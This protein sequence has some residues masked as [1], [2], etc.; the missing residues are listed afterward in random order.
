MRIGVNCY[1]MQPH[2]GG[3]RQYLINLLNQVVVYDTDNT[4]VLFCFE[5]NIRYLA[6]I[7]SDRWLVD[8]VHLTAMAQ[9]RHHLRDVDVYFS[10][11]N[12]LQPTALRPLPTVIM[13]PDAQEVYYPRYFTAADLFYRDWYCR[14]SSHLAD[15]VITISHFSKQTIA[16]HYRLSPDR[17][18][19]AYPCIDDRF[20]RA[21]TIARAPD[22]ALPETFILYPANRWRHKNHAALLQ[23]MQLIQR[24]SGLRIH[25]VF[26]GVDE[27][28]GYD[29]LAEA[30][31]AGLG[32]VVH[33]LGHVPVEQM[34]YLYRRA[35][36][37]VFPSL[38]EGFGLPL[39]EAMATGC[40]IAASKCTSL[41]EVAGEAALY[42]DPNSP[43]DIAATVQTLWSDEGLRARLIEI[44]FRRASMF[45]ATQTMQA[46]LE[47]WKA[48]AETYSPQRYWRNRLLYLPIQLLRVASKRTAGVYGRQGMSTVDSN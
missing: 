44:G 14:V 28:N 48:A 43:E 25:A 1:F 2:V 19:V 13:L 37:L 33:K 12:G 40:P 42:F 3:V 26:T 47:A 31:R 15:Q 16:R 41:P 4:Y 30:V 6:E 18:R 10:P 22:Y 36:M 35:R 11:I 23:A 5:H 34:V 46:H 39:V 24:Q 20:N 21:D 7:G 32:G 8:A 27:S 45:S 29:L 9:I 38:F 17:I